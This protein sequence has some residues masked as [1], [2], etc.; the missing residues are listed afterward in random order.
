MPRRPK[1]RTLTA[2]SGSYVSLPAGWARTDPA[3]VGPFVTH[4]SFHGPDGPG[5][6]DWTAS[7]VQ[8]V[9]TVFFT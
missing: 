6:I 3:G 2:L 9:G 8:L 1:R 5:R 4:E 7:S